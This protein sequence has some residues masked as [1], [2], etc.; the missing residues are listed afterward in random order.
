LEP[1]RQRVEITRVDIVVG[2]NITGQLGQLTLPVVGSH[3][4]ILDPLACG[5]IDGVGNISVQFHPALDLPKTAVLLKPAT[6]TIAKSRPQVIFAAAPIATVGEF[7]AGHCHKQPPGPLND[8]EI[9]DGETTVKGDGAKRVQAL[10]LAPLI[11]QLDP[12]F[13]DFHGPLLDLRRPQPC[14][15]L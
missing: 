15:G 12:D 4:G 8:L 6:A 7:A 13:G 11:H 9:P 2:G 5:G 3:N 14:Q 1:V 10:V